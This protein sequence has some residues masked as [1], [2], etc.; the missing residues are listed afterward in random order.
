MILEVE[1]DRHFLLFFREI[2]SVVLHVYINNT[3]IALLK[4]LVFVSGAI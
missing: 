4:L 1:S 3:S 2:L